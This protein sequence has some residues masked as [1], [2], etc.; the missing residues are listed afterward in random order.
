MFIFGQKILSGSEHAIIGNERL[1]SELAPS[2][3]GRHATVK[4]TSFLE[5]PWHMTLCVSAAKCSISKDAD[6]TSRA[7]S[8]RTDGCEKCVVR[9]RFLEVFVSKHQTFS[10]LQIE[11]GRHT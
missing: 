4:L 9:A 3:G 2:L 6:S 7:L 1:M 10:D 11:G 5:M 8:A